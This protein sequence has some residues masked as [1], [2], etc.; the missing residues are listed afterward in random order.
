LWYANATVR[1]ISAVFPTDDEVAQVLVGP[2]SVSWQRGSDARLYLVMLYPLL[3]QVAHPTVGAGVRDYSDFEKRPWDRLLRTLDYVNL[4]V[5]GGR[6]A[7]ETGRRLRALHKRFRGIREDGDRYYALE[8]S[9]Y[10]WVHATLLETYV[11]G[12]ARFGTPMNA[13]E[14]ERFYR[15]YRGLGRLIG[16]RDSDLPEDWRGFREY[17][18]D[19]VEHQLVRT[20][21]VDRVLG[22]I[23]HAAPPPLPL[24]EALWPLLR[25]PARRALFV[26]GV[27]LMQPNLRER[28]GIRW[29]RADSAQFELLGLISRRLTPVMPHRLRVMGPGHLRWRRRAIARGPLGGARPDAGRT[30]PKAA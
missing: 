11:A 5:Y 24:P 25:L 27:G 3:L 10:A 19:V 20:D 21:S 2:D 9:A 1:T 26:G 17:F 13:R 14:V 7:V 29:A 16:V 12:H 22:A 8:P 23:S 30:A 18:D 15:E 4:L 28:L 6:D